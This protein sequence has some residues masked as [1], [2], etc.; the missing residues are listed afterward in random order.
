MEF[1]P[2]KGFIGACRPYFDK[3]CELGI[4]N[5]HILRIH[6]KLSSWRPVEPHLVFKPKNLVL[7]ENS[8]PPVANHGMPRKIVLNT[9]N[10]HFPHV[11]LFKK[12]ISIEQR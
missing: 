11:E 7:G 10:L 1:R 3:P 2:V 8:A 4:G 12:H 5:E 9:K 6:T